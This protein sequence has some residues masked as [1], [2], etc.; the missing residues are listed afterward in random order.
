MYK[1]HGKHRRAILP[2]RSKDL[3]RRKSYLICVL[4]MNEVS[5]RR[6]WLVA[7]SLEECGASDTSY[8]RKPEIITPER[9]L[10]CHHVS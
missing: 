1:I 2:L 10:R 5:R 3:F 9:R 8:D 6:R 7:L 4:K